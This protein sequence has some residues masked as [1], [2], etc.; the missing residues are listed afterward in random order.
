MQFYAIVMIF[1]T[2]NKTSI[3]KLIIRCGAL[4]F[5]ST[6]ECLKRYLD[7]PEYIV[8]ISEILD[9]FMNSANLSQNSTIFLFFTLYKNIIIFVMKFITFFRN[10]ITLPLISWIHFQ[11]S[12]PSKKS[13]TQYSKNLNNKLIGEQKNQFGIN[14]IN[15]IIKVKEKLY[16]SKKLFF[17]WKINIYLF[18]KP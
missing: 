3:W 2:K 10:F 8:R 16:S 4:G 11:Q 13:Y 5:R 1:I 7:Y 17:P 12:P 9:G 6:P 18:S 14:E 15:G